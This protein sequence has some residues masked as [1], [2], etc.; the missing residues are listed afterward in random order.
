M[1]V[2]VVITPTYI[3]LDSVFVSLIM[4]GHC[5]DKLQTSM[6]ISL[7]PNLISIFFSGI[8]FI[9]PNTNRMY[10][11]SGY[12]LF[13]NN[14]L[15]SGKRNSHV[16]SNSIPLSYPCC[17]N[18]RGIEITVLRAAILPDVTI[19]VQVRQLHNL[20]YGNSGTLFF[21]F[22]WFFFGFFF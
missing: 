11:L 4:Q 7:I 6:Q 18:G 15:V 2:V 12:S 8:R 22:V 5:T 9:D 21:L 13:R 10:A 1:N 20:N 3:H 16:P 19:V 14:S 17:I